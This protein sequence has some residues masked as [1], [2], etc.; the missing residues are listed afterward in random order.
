MPHQQTTLAGLLQQLQD[1]VES[2]AFWSDD[3]GIRALNQSLRFWNLLTGMWKQQVVVSTPSPASPYVSLPGS[4]TYGMSVVWGATGKP[5]ALSALHDLDYGK[6]RWEE[7]T[8]A[9]GGVVPTVPTLWCPSG[10]RE[11]VVWPADAATGMPLMVEGVAVTPVLAALTDYVDMGDQD[12][13]AVVG[14]ALNI[15]AFKRGPS[16]LAATNKYV[17]E[18]IQAAAA[19]NERLKYSAVFR[20]YLGLDMNKGFRPIVNTRPRGQ[21]GAGQGQG[22][23]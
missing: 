2:A 13:T 15:L 20:R 1:T 10:L 22:E 6:P 21:A 11:L 17:T 7:Q 19:Q 4:I 9:S 12:S 23:Q 14:M 3:E 5:L 8:T 18:F 16:A